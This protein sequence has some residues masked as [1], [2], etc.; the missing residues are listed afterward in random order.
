MRLTA[1]I[2]FKTLPV[3]TGMPVARSNL[4]KSIMFSARLPCSKGRALLPDILAM[5]RLRHGN[6][7]FH[8][9]QDAGSFTASDLGN[10][11]LI[12]KQSPEC[13]IDGGR[14]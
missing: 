5:A 8:L 14:I 1:R 4:A 9:F 11:I 10:V 2:A 3:P 13:T 7:E 6:L 12:F